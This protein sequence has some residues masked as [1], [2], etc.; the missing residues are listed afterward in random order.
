MLPRLVA[1]DLDGT[2]LPASKHLTPRATAAVRGAREAGAEVVLATGKTFHLA[3][4]YAEELGLSGPVIALDGSLVR[5]W[6]GGDTLVSAGIPADRAREVLDRLGDLDLRTF[7]TDGTDR[8]LMDDRL[9]RWAWFLSAYSDR[10]TATT[11]PAAEAVGDPFFVAALGEYSDVLR[12]GEAL[13]DLGENGLRVFT[14]E[15]REPGVGLLVVKPRTSK[16]AALRTVAERLGVPREE[17]V[18]IGDW[19]NDVEMVRW[20]GT[21]VAMADAH[22][23]VLAVADVVLPGTCE[24][25]GVAAYLEELTRAS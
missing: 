12:G 8:F 5:D 6:P 9:D 1:I 2:L 13:R 24:T 3:A 23:E 14:A 20:A 16:G 19:R 4:C 7:L 10:V 11:A 15:F 21:G 17:T 18:A 25:D 22:P